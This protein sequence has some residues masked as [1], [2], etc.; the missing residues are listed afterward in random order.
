[1]DVNTCYL[2]EVVPAYWCILVRNNFEG[3]SLKSPD[4]KGGCPAWL[5]WAAHTWPSRT[6]PCT[7]WAQ[8]WRW[9]ARTSAR[10][11]CQTASGPARCTFLQPGRSY[12][13]FVVKTTTFYFSENNRFWYGSG[14]A[15][16]DYESWSCSLLQWLLRSKQK[17]SFVS[18]FFA[19]C[20]L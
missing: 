13:V 18:K 8:W 10:C 9:W 14:S 15:P 12:I 19:Y 17:R 3:L 7:C 11:R 1:M 2:L 5:P 16:L 4:R 6:S 20:L